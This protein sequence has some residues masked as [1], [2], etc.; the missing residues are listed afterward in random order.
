[1]KIQGTLGGHRNGYIG[2]PME[3]G[4]LGPRRLPGAP[5]PP[6]EETDVD[7]AGIDYLCAVAKRRERALLDAIP[8][9]DYDEKD[10]TNARPSQSWSDAD[11]GELIRRVIGGETMDS[12]AHG[13]LRTHA[14]VKKK[15]MA[16]RR[17]MEPKTKSQVAAMS[18]RKR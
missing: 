10:A 8:D 17:A 7:E 5:P 3:Q 4:S 1:M 11:V 14:S 16:L 15:V 12:I 2:A 6:M 9:P 18:N 13:M